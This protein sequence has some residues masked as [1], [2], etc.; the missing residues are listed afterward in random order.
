MS[1]ET[2]Q[3][4]H[5][6]F[7]NECMS[8]T[9]IKEEA[10]LLLVVILVLA[11]LRRQKQWIILSGCLMLKVKYRL[12]KTIFLNLK[13]QLLTCQKIKLINKIKSEF[14]LLNIKLLNIINFLIN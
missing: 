2:I 3:M 12:Y 4:M 7:G 6:A 14:E 5:K 8:K 11:D 10:A 9:R 13:T 1:S